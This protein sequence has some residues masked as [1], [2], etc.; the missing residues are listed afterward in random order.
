LE[1]LATDEAFVRAKDTRASV[2]LPVLRNALAHGGI[3]YL[4]KDGLA[5]DRPAAMYAFVSEQMFFASA[6]PIFARF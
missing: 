6:S 2:I 5:T 1:A 4:D 3:A